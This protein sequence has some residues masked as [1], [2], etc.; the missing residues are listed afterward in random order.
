MD[1]VSV[2]KK[3]DTEVASRSSKDFGVKVGEK[4]FLALV[5]AGKIKKAKFGV[6]GTSLFECELPAYDGVYAVT[7]DWEIGDDEFAVGT[8]K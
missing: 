1:T 6:M 5:Q 7:L 8:P 4:L 2:I 3:I